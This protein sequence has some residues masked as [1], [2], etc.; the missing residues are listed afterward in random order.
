MLRRKVSTPT[1]WL[2]IWTENV[3]VTQQ[4]QALDAGQ[5]EFS[6]GAMMS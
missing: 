4:F 6:F 5:F 1:G 3:L 2:K